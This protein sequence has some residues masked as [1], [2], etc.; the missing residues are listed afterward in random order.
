MKILAFLLLNTFVLC[1]QVA[2]NSTNCTLEQVC[3][4]R[5][6]SKVLECKCDFKGCANM[7]EIRSDKL[8]KLLEA[9]AQTTTTPTL[10]DDE[11]YAIINLQTNSPAPATTVV[12][13]T[14]RPMPV[15]NQIFAFLQDKLYNMFRFMTM[16][17][18]SRPR[19]T[20]ETTRTTSTSSTTSTI[21]TAL[22]TTDS[23][24]NFTDFI[25][26]N[27]ESLNISNKSL[28]DAK[29]EG[30][31]VVSIERPKLNDEAKQAD[32]S[33][34]FTVFIIALSLVC[35]VQI[36]ITVFTVYFICTKRKSEV[37]KTDLRSRKVASAKP[38]EPDLWR[39]DSSN[40]YAKTASEVSEGPT[41]FPRSIF[42]KSEFVARPAI[43]R[44]T[45]EFL[46]EKF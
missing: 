29:P 5:W 46:R 10:I 44:L 27:N 9:A 15:L 20:I 41:S 12:M 21:L 4:C 22:V 33:G 19:A 13:S 26:V 43:V 36:V 23:Q 35:L 30:K 42:A 16:T 40:V 1:D 38:F 32:N 17:S 34:V 11:I 37:L 25:L 7:S 39:R 14:T 18:P 3:S 24:L 2:T 45:P 31:E 28:I 8:A 6:L